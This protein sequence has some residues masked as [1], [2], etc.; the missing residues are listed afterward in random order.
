MPAR[1]FTRA[2]HRAVGRTRTPWTDAQAAAASGLSSAGRRTGVAVATSGMVVSLVATPAS[3]TM[4]SHHES[5]IA[6]LD[7]ARLTSAARAAIE[8]TPVVATPA[9]ATWTFDNPVATAVTPPPTPEPEPEPERA[10]AATRSTARDEASVP[11]PQIG[12]PAPSSANGS[13]I[14]EAASSLVG[15]PYV[16]GGTTPSG[17]DC[18]GFTSYVYAQVGMK[19]PR[20]SAAQRYAGVEV[21]RDQAQPGDLIWSPGHISIFAGGNLQVD[22]PVPGKAVQ[23]REIWQS[24][25]VFIRVG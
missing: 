3:A 23:I 16:W 2:R 18:S 20:T 15:V 12:A 4:P 8:S 11:S 24:S 1:P 14:V 21:P 5:R 22:A 25:P 7:T 13:A 19:L 17:F 9:E 6:P 10:P